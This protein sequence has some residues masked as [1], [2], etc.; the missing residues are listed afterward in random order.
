MITN[1]RRALD[2]CSALRRSTGEVSVV[3]AHAQRGPVGPHRWRARGTC[4]W[5]ISASDAAIAGIVGAMPW[6]RRRSVRRQPP[7]AGAAAAVTPA[8]FRD[9]ANEP[10]VMSGNVSQFLAPLVI[11]F[12]RGFS[13]PP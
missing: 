12:Q 11:L 8:S 9:I 10:V 7:G 13:L 1:C 6:W 2:T 4:R 3:H 5:S